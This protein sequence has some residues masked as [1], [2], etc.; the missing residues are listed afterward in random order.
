M[1]ERNLHSEFL[2][3]RAHLL[4]VIENKQKLGTHK[5]T[6]SFEQD[7]YTRTQS[8]VQAHARAKKHLYGVQ[9]KHDFKWSGDFLNNLIISH[10]RR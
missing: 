4:L 8:E 2:M 1:N 3:C 7:I 5:H 9:L 10:H 6:G